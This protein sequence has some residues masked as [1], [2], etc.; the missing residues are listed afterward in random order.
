M[1]VAG[2]VGWAFRA[3]PVGATTSWVALGASDKTELEI[4]IAGPPGSR[5]WLLMT[6]YEDEGTGT[7]VSVPRVMTGG[8]TKGITVLGPW[9][10]GLVV[11]AGRLVESGAGRLDLLWAGPLVVLGPGTG[12]LVESTM[13]DGS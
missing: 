8:A 2:G 9:T 7:K 13:V 3:V 12:I 11:L 4:V 6:K 5:V 10:R 1:V